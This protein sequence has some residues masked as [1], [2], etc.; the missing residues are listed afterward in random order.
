MAWF[1]GKVNLRDINFSK[2]YT[3][4]FSDVTHK[5]GCFLYTFYV[6]FHLRAI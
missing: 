6:T 2:V 3:Y 5:I 4:A 1:S